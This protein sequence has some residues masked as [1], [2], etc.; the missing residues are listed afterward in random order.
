LEYQSGDNE[1]NAH[2]DQGKRLLK[3]EIKEKSLAQPGK[4]SPQEEERKWEESSSVG[5]QI[6]EKV[7]RVKTI[8]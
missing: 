1:G 5:D 8:E 3:E 7:N 2:N 6:L 4:S